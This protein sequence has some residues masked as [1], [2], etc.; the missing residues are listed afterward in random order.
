MTDDINSTHY[1]FSE[2][3][4]K[5]L[6]VINSCL[7][8]DTLIELDAD[9]MDKLKGRINQALTSYGKINGSAVRRMANDI[10]NSKKKK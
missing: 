5:L 9:S 8:T 10:L 1:R 6:G 4:A 3:E 2:L 7:P